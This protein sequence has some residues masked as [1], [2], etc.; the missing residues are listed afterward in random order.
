M[1]FTESVRSRQTPATPGTC[2]WPPS[3]PSVPTSRATL[4]TWAAKPFSWSTIVLTVFFSSNI[5]PATSTVTLRDR[6]PLATAVVTCAMLRTCAVSRPAMVLTESARSFQLPDTLRTFAWPPSLPSV[7]T[8]RA[9]RVTSSVNSDNW[10]T[11]P[12][13]VRPI[14]RYSPRNGWLT[15]L[16][17]SERS[18]IFW[19]RSPSAIELSTRPTSAIGRARS[20]I[21]ELQLSTAA[22]QAPSPAPVS[23]RSFSRPSRP[24]ARRTRAS[25]PVRCWLRSATSLNTAAISA[26]GPSPGTVSRRR[27]FPSR[28][29]VSA[30]SSLRSSAGSAPRLWLARRPAALRGAAPDRP[31][32]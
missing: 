27:K 21:N 9:T 19:S 11:S 30:A 32:R 14:F 10:S 31:P 18:S 13:T 17:C 22:I 2:A 7:P 28:I 29:A 6:S 3:L 5:S 12:L 8:S 4:V 20:S 23:S 1:K 24:T 15:P 16:L 26:S 25:S